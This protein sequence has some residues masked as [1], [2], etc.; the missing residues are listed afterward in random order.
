M[1]T[2]IKNKLHELMMFHRGAAGGQPPPN[3]RNLFSE[4]PIDLVFC[5][6]SPNEAKG[7]KHVKGRDGW[8]LHQLGGS[9]K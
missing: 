1:L 2:S 3:F 6:Q 9:K 5:Q 7:G 4:S 8:K